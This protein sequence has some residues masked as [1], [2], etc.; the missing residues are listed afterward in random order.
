MT[1]FRRTGNRRRSK[2]SSC[3]KIASIGDAVARFNGLLGEKIDWPDYPDRVLIVGWD[4][5]N[6]FFLSLDT[7]R[8]ETTAAVGQC[9]GILAGLRPPKWY[10]RLIFG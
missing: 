7:F 8:F 1:A 3:C 2:K 10:G 5:G 6:R 4:T 9:F